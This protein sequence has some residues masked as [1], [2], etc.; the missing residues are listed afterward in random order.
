MEPDSWLG[1]ELR[2]LAALRAVAREG[3][4]AAAAAALGYTQSAISQ[5]IAMLERII[6]APVLDR[7]G[8]RRPAVL[9]E[10]GSALVEHAEAIIAR[11]H[12]ARADVAAIVVGEAGTLRVGTYQSIGMRILP[13]LLRDFR[14]SWPQVDIRLHEAAGDAALLDR[15]RDGSLDLTFV[16]LPPTSAPLASVELLRDPY[17]LVVA[18]TSPLARRGRPLA[19]RELAGLPLIALRTC[20]HQALL[21]AH[22]RASGV[23][24]QI[25]FASDDNGTVQS[26]V[27]TGLG[28][29]LVPRLT[30]DPDDDATAIVELAGRL[31]PRA[32]GIVW[33]GDRYQS[34]AASAFVAAAQRAFAGF[35][36]AAGVWGA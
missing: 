5:Q 30:M 29:A 33:H 7:P 20:S 24:P 12:A 11:L 36:G 32:L 2:H 28:A 9:T 8:G 10:V 13:H 16:T 3:S 1:L 14:A 21:E 27:A 4:F 23:E 18:S 19:L 17:V 25:V 31:P 34:P 26:L 6:G 15:V 22:L 35:T